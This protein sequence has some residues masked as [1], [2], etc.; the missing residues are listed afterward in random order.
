LVNSLCTNQVMRTG[1]LLS[2]A[3][4]ARRLGVSVSTA[5]RY[6]VSGALESVRDARGWVFARPQAVVA[7]RRKRARKVRA[8]NPKWPGLGDNRSDQASMCGGEARQSGG[9]RLPSSGESE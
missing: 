6:M 4:V 3:A 1:G 8:V 2:P 7:F 5:K 9:L